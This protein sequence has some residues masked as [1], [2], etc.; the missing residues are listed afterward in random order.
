MYMPQLICAGPTKPSRK[1]DLCVETLII[2]LTSLWMFVIN[3]LPWSCLKV[4]LSLFPP[5]PVFIGTSQEKSHLLKH[6]LSHV[7][8]FGP[9]G[10][11]P[12]SL[13]CPWNSPGK[14]AGV[15]CHSLLQWIFLTQGLNP[16]FCIA[17][18]FF[19]I[20]ATRETQRKVIGKE[21]EKNAYLHRLL[22]CHQIYFLLLHPY[23]SSNICC[24][25][26][27][28]LYHQK[29]LL[30]NFILLTLKNNSFLDDAY[31]YISNHHLSTFFTLTYKIWIH[32]NRILQE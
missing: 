32:L 3:N 10:L 12:G 16:I 31:T 1:K 18:R 17:S 9:S 22:L 13:L 2:C 25:N 27:D 26:T 8:L 14:N 28:I 6:L 20:W 19:T 7:R 4:T 23:G 21:T 30:F 11:W 24:Q 5:H 29:L 15:G